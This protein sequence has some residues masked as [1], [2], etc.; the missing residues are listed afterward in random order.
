[1]GLERLGTCCSEWSPKPRKR[2]GQFRVETGRGRNQYRPWRSWIFRE[3]LWAQG[4]GE[5]PEAEWEE[6][7]RGPGGLGPAGW[8]RTKAYWGPLW[9][10]FGERC[11]VGWGEDRL[12][13]LAGSLEAGTRGE[14]RSSHTLPYMD[15]AWTSWSTWGLYPDQPLLAKILIFSLIVKPFST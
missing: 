1:M 10:Q 7:P 15:G 2:K 14:P 13:L 5:E 8:S 12:F 3:S 4:R 9:G 6:L 11:W